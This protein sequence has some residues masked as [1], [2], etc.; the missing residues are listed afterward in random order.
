MSASTP[1][2]DAVVADLGPQPSFDSSD[3]EF[4]WEDDMAKHRRPEPAPAR[5]FDGVRPADW[6]LHLDPA[7]RDLD[8]TLHLDPAAEARWRQLAADAL[9]APAPAPEPAPAQ[10]VTRYWTEDYREVP[11]PAGHVNH[12]TRAYYARPEV[13]PPAEASITVHR[14]ELVPGGH[15]ARI[16]YSDDHPDRQFLVIPDGP[17]Q[18]Y[19]RDWWAGGLEH[20]E[21][22]AEGFHGVPPA[23]PA[24]APAPPRRRLFRNPRFKP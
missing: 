12:V 15:G 6:T 19:G 23:E 17:P 10:P 22:P 9:N 3:F 7:R 2:F 13:P 1:I 11:P 21:P 4:R 20:L 8:W 5:E 16:G 18:L 24:P 14:S